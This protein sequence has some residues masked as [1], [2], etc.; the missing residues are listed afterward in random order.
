MIYEK[1][2]VPFT[3]H[4]FSGDEGTRRALKLYLKTITGAVVLISLTIW[5]ILGI[6]WGA[7]W[8]VYQGIHN[9]NGWI[10]DFDGGAIGSIITQA[11]LNA[12][13]PQEQLS[14]Y[15]VPTS[16]F[17]NGPSDIVDAVLN[18]RCW[19]AVVINSG[20]TDRLNAAVASGSDANYNNSDAVT[21]YASEARNEN[22]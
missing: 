21:I 5:S 7:N 20:A 16:N 14:W 9:L 6:Y 8:R 2:D 18:E 15:T 12:T 22:S 10:V 3:H 1:Q 13:G 4:V 11:Y 19:A 17:P